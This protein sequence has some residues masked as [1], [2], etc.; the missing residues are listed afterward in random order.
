M[1]KCASTATSDLPSPFVLFSCASFPACFEK[2]IAD[3][4]RDAEDDEDF[5]ESAEGISPMARGRESKA[6]FVEP[7]KVV[8]VVG[9][10]K[11]RKVG[12][13]RKWKKKKRVRS[14]SEV[15]DGLV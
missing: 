15:S 7:D 4:V 10:T 8:I 3:W 14:L 11:L 5:G 9:W 2:F 12:R 13:S 6:G 1:T